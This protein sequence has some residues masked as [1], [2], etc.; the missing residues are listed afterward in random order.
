MIK[1]VLCLLKTDAH[2]HF[3]YRLRLNE[4]RKLA[5]TI[6]YEILNEFIQIRSGPQSRYFL[7][8]GKVQEIKE[9]VDKNDV[10]TVIFYNVLKSREKLNLSRIFGHEVLDRYELT[11]KIFEKTSSDDLSKLQIEAARLHKLFPYFKLQA[12]LTSKREH[13]SFMGG[14]EYSYHNQV[15]VLRKRMSNIKEKI[16]KLKTEGELRI[17][18]RKELGYPIIC[19][20]GYY[21]SGKTSLFNTLTGS[22]K[23][24]GQGQPFTTLSSKYQKLDSPS[25]DA[26]LMVDTIG[27]VIDLDPRLIG[28][29]E[30]NLQDIR[31]ADIVL[32]L[33]E[34]SDSIQVLLV[35]LESGFELLRNID[36]DE[37]RIVIV[38]NKLDLVSE[39][40]VN[41]ISLELKPYLDIYDSIFISTLKKKNLDKLIELIKIKLKKLS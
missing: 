32:F 23:K 8:K 13:P 20:S 5:E 34:I 10:D 17:R 16:E 27:F 26:M 7:G 24:V 30:L 25:S 12:E 36:V 4:L 35:K 21:N 18:K 31:S 14:G 3:L 29:F 33:L 28:S 19:I 37:K 6:G 11:L 15:S 2:D 40:H 39:E 1:A 9:Y 38:F 22:S 41:E